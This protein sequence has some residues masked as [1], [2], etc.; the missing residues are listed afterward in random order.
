[1][2]SWLMLS[3]AYCYHISE[4]PIKIPGIVITKLMLLVS[5]CPKVITLSSFHCADHNKQCYKIQWGWV[6]VNTVNI[7]VLFMWSYRPS[8]L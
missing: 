6:I 1:M 5:V 7:I 2:W 4:V 8:N 3:A